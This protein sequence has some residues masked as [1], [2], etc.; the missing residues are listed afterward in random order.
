MGIKNT[1]MTGIIKVRDND[2]NNIPQPEYVKVISS[3]HKDSSLIINKESQII[4]YKI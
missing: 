3:N 2:E 1:F 4:I